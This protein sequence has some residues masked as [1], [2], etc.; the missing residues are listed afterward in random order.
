M[1]V[2]VFAPDTPSQNLPVMVWI[3]GG[4]FYLGAG[5]EPLYDGSTLAAQGEVIVVT[6][7]YRLG[8]FGFTCLHL[9]RRIP[10][11]LGF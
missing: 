1:F 9:M 2:N 11:T 6:L 5:S 4:A 7:N 3:H 10:I 8:P